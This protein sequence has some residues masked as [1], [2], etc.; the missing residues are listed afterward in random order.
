MAI[1]TNERRT[2][3]PVIS[4]VNS[5]GVAEL[6]LDTLSAAYEGLNDQNITY[7]TFQL[8]D[9]EVSQPD[10][11]AYKFYGDSQLWWIICLFNGIVD[12]YTELQAGVKLKVPRLDEVLLYLTRDDSAA[13]TSQTNR[14][15]ATGVI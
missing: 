14:V 15:G 4:I 12:P 11:V 1:Q 8:T 10:A 5:Q 2:Y 13:S 9:S 6:S 7:D 3:C